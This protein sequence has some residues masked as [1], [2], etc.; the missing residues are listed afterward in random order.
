MEECVDADEMLSEIQYS[1]CLLEIIAEE[2]VRQI[3]I[4]DERPIPKYYDDPDDPPVE[5]CVSLFCCL[6]KLSFNR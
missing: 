6:S 2:L 3:K 1:L 4:L 5:K